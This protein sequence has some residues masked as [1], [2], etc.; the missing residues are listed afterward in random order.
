M[1]FSATA[2]FSV[3]AV[4]M[5]VAAYSLVKARREPRWLA[6]AA[7][8]LAFGLQQ[9]IEGVV[10]LAL[11]VG[12]PQKVALAGRGFLFFSHFFWPAWVPYS[13]YRL[14]RAAQPWRRR[15]LFTLAVTGALFGASIGV[16]SLLF[17]DWLSVE[18]VGGSVE[19]HTVL[20]YD[21]LVSRSVLKFAYA[22][23]VVVALVLSA[24]RSVQIFGG[25]ILASLL[26]ADH[27]YPHA[28]IS[29]WCFFAAI[30]SI[31][32]SIM[33]AMRVRRGK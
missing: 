10:W 25:I 16:P 14:E 12:E 11:T 13:V 15:L 31:Y 17:D 2:S 32:V 18:V 29:V 7:Y 1:C 9:A 4:L 20:L 33:I 5:P 23:I 6:F 27:F 30:L 24:E 28:F 19:Y 3:A 26:V 21:D 22:A 8:P